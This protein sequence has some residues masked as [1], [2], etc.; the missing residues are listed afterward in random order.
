MAH[1]ALYHVPL[2][3]PTNKLLP[4]YKSNYTITKNTIIIKKEQCPINNHNHKNEK[5]YPISTQIQYTNQY[6][7]T[8]KNYCNYMTTIIIK[9]C[10]IIK[11]KTIDSVLLQKHYPL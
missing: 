3:V 2:L 1:E 7:S 6:T 11:N 5:H 4:Y 9:K 8:R 10:P